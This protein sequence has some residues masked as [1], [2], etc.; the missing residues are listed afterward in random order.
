[1]LDDYIKEVAEKFIAAG[2]WVIPLSR[3]TKQAVVKWKLDENPRI[4]KWDFKWSN[5]AMIT[6]EQNGYAVVECDN[7]DS[8]KQ[9]LA[10]RPRTPL[11]VKSPRGMH[12]YYRHPGV[13]V[14]SDSK[15]QAK[16]GFEYD[17][18]GDNS[19]CMAPPSMRNGKQ[20]QV[21]VCTGNLD[22]KWLRPEKLPMF[23]PAWRPERAKNYTGSGSKEIK[24]VA[25]VLACRSC[26][27][28]ERD[29]W[30]YW[31]TKICKEGNLSEGEAI[32][33]V[34]QWHQTNVNPPWD[35]VEIIAKVRREYE[36]GK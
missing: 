26:G 16:E 34:T 36:K 30:T 22:A 14:K 15:I 2:F 21:C 20:Y 7:A 5:I 31:A 17:V 24:D 27:E 33:M 10:H 9:W 3:K 29:K 28:G 35:P 12:F 6:G 11:R 13:Y 4:T 32:Q 18:K 25:K 23:D 19:Y 8:Y 1:M